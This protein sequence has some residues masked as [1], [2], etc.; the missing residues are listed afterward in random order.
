VVKTLEPYGG[1]PSDMAALL[2]IGANVVFPVSVAN[3]IGL[4]GGMLRI[5]VDGLT[6]YEDDAEAATG[7]VAVGEFYIWDCSTAGFPA[8]LIRKRLA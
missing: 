8:Y 3:D 1:Y 5:N 6:T 7:G 2:A 4:P